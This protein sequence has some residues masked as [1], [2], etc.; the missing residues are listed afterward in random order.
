MFLLT[1]FIGQSQT[2][3]N[4]I[5]QPYIEVNGYADTAITPD[6]IY[7]KIIISEKD[8][9]DKISLEELEI[10]M[11]NA[12]KNMGINTDKDL[13]TSDVVSNFKYYFLR[14]KEAVKTKQYILKVSDA[15]T[16]TKVIS[17][18]EDLD[19]SNTS[20]DRVNY[21]DMENMKNLVRTKAVENAKA[22]AVALT[23]P[24]NQT[25]GVAIYISDIAPGNFNMQ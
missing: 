19:I 25:V 2:T 21:S 8:T 9:K 4:F 14:G 16:V 18:L 10:K 12:L 7:I 15:V 17:Q 6:E 23:K 13:T 3:K 20:I 24:L 5:D 22:S 1:V 11:V